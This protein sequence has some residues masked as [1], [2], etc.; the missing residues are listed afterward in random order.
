M[1]SNVTEITIN[2][3]VTSFGTIKNLYE[4]I[5]IQL[6]E[7]EKSVDIIPV[8]KDDNNDESVYITLNKQQ[9]LA[10]ASILKSIA[11]LI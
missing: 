6:D 8:L 2:A 7:H 3:M 9:C 11:S 1:K 4:D 5:K 10:L